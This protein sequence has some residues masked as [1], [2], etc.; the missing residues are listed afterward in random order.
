MKF[1]TFA[2][3]SSLSLRR[4]SNRTSTWLGLS[5]R[6]LALLFWYPSCF[7]HRAAKGGSGTPGLSI[8]LMV[9]RIRSRD[10]AAQAELHGWPGGGLVPNAAITT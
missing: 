7:S 2:F 6:P 1:E 10:I 9:F 4:L 8:Q 3:V 5:V